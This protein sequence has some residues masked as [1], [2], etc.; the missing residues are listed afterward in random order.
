M[1]DFI[2][3]E[4]G[5]VI[6]LFPHAVVPFIMFCITYPYRYVIEERGRRKLYQAFSYYVSP[7]VIDRLV[8]NDADHLMKGERHNVCIMF[9]DIRGFTALSEKYESESIVS[10]LNIFFERVT[11]IVQNHGGFVNKF[12]GDGMLAFF[13][14][15][16]TYVDDS[17]DASIEICRLTTEI[18]SSGIL[19]PH[20]GDDTLAIGI[21]LHAGTVILGNIGSKRKMDFTVI[22]RAVNAASRIESLTKDYSR[23]ILLSREVKS[24]SIKGYA[25][26]PLG[27]AEV[28]GI[29]GG[30]EIFG[31]LQ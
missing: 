6:P 7:E 31:L 17:I 13:A 19:K 14:V 3:F 1:A 25:F 20:I 2:F 8:I 12:I 10:M 26:E 16:D 18:N 11:E 15:G 21:G 27:T 9:L 24:M 4:R 5:V 28:K 29:S 30:V 22:G 23:S